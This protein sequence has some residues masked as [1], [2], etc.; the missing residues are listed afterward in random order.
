MSAPRTLL[1]YLQVTATFLA[2]KGI[3]GAKL[4]AELL[5][6]E[7]LGMTRTQLY[8]NFEQPLGAAEIGR[9]RDLVRRRAARE[10][11]AYITGR[12]EFWSL[13]FDVDRRVLV[14]RPETELVVE[15]AVDALR[16]RPDG[17]SGAALVADIGTGSGAIAVAIAKEMKHARVI[18]TDRSEAAL[19]IAPANSAR[20][21]VSDRIEFRLGD[22][23][24]PL[25]GCGLFDAIVS[26]PPYIRSEEMRTLPPEVGQWEP[27]W[28]LEAGADGMDVTAPLVDDAFEMLAPGGVLLVEVGTQSARVRERF[29]SRGYDQVVVRRDLAGI[30]RVVMG[31]RRA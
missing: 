30:D 24:A 13:E 20:H 3:D 1:E 9:Y 5:L 18:A 12:R 7:V 10:P 25:A 31:R 19:E 21:G 27:R 2:S 11:V 29:V 16:T 28:A 17:D 4:D 14:P 22:G 23:C 15:L 26:N 6:A 8:T